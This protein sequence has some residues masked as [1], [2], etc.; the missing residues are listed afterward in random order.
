MIYI[1]I[2]IN[3]PIGSSLFAVSHMTIYKTYACAWC[4]LSHPAPPG[5]GLG[6]ALKDRGGRFPS[7]CLGTKYLVPP[8]WYLSGTSWM[9]C[10]WISLSNEW[11][12][13]TCIGP[14]SYMHVQCNPAEHD[15]YASNLSTW[16]PAAWLPVT[17]CWMRNWFS[18][19]CLYILFCFDIC[20]AP[21]WLTSSHHSKPH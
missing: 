11:H 16:V 13:P 20:W 12:V 1:Y 19:H 21:V 10:V 9:T 15:T 17:H 4:V 14:K 6:V 3:I 18:V 2:Y 7:G 5:P 8:P